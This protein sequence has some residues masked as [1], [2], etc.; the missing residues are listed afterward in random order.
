MNKV[1]SLNAVKEFSIKGLDG[2]FGRVK[3]FYFTDQDWT[4]RYLVA[5]THKL[6]GD[7][8][9]LIG[10]PSLVGLDRGNRQ[11]KVNLTK[12]QI[13]DSPTKDRARPGSIL[14]GSQ[15]ATCGASF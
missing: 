5:H 14:I 13:E 10:S 7:R 11:L 3:E 6:V 9:V 8:E 15:S 12:S 2:E 1:I 4:I